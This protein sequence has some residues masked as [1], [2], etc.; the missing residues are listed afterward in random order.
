MWD[1]PTLGVACNSIKQ[2]KCFAYTHTNTYTVRLRRKVHTS[3]A[4]SN[5]FKPRAQCSLIL[6]YICKI[7]PPSPAP[8]PKIRF[9]LGLS[10]ADAK[11]FRLA[12]Y[13]VSYYH[14]F[15]LALR[16]TTTESRKICMFDNETEAAEWN[17]MLRCKWKGNV[18]LIFV[19]TVFW[20][21][22]RH[23]CWERIWA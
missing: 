10:Q 1:F 7:S 3:H 5:E 14:I 6:V 17:E 16:C 23:R 4:K 2:I 8:P 20:S 22:N 11:S 21:D 12:E 13:D 19:G 9:Y 15:G 18:G